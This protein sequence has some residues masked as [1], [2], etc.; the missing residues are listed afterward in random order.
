MRSGRH[1]LIIPRQDTKADAPQVTSE[2]SAVA[3][4]IWRMFTEYAWWDVSWWIGVLFSIGSAIFIASGF[5][6]WLPLAAPSTEF[7]GEG[8]V[9]GGVTAF[10]GATL[11]QIG[12][13]LLIVEA[14]NE[15]QSGCFGW[16]LEQAFSHSDTDLNGS[17]SS[18]PNSPSKDTAKYYCEHH[19]IKGIHRRAT[20]ASQHPSA[21]RKWEWWPTWRELRDHYF[22]EIGFL[23]SFILAIGATIFYI[24]G[25]LALPGVYSALSQGVDYGVYWLS[26]LVGGILFVI[27]SGLYII[28]TQPN[29]YTPEPKLLGWWI[30]VWNM[31]GSVGWTLSASFGYCS[32]HWCEYQ[33]DLSLLWASVAFTIGS[34]LLWYE[35]LDKY[36]VERE[37]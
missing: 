24:S 7:K 22:H 33:S 13:V 20:L 17:P 37:K 10:I 21:G 14:C 28:E 1:A 3:K 35:A 31:I 16:A 9:A 6:Y 19:H 30:G 32:A 29:W 15:N 8:S 4:G 27:S 36:P 26:Y 12:A 25:I 5:F 2:W 34:L 23:A 11:F 18:P